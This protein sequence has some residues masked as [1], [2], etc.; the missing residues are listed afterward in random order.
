MILDAVIPQLPMHGEPKLW[1]DLCAAPGGKTGILAR[2]VGKSDVLVAN[3]LN[4]TRLAVL[5]ENLVKGGYLNTF[6]AG[7]S[8][9]A[10]PDEAADVILVDAPCTGEGMM[11]KETEAIEQWS[12]SLVQSCSLL[13]REI[14]REAFRICKP[15]GYILYSTC[16]Y[17]P[18][19][20]IDNVAGFISS[21]PADP[22]E[23]TFPSS[24][25]ISTQEMGLA[26]GYQLFPHLV[27]GEG[28]FISVLRKHEKKS[29][30]GKPARR[31][32][33]PFQSLPA[34]IHP[35][36]GTPEAYV[37]LADRPEL[38]AFT[39]SAA[40]QAETVLSGIP[41][42]EPISSFGEIKG[43]DYV[44]SH[45]LAM[46]GLVS[47]R[48]LPVSLD[49]ERALDYLERKIPDN[50]PESTPGWYPVVYASTMLGWCKRTGQGWKNH[51]PMHWRLRNRR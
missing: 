38:F 31:T 32:R 45:F 50:L 49:Y 42:A 19:E 12:P 22:V 13:Q 16:S 8:A 2:H 4:R 14:V 18:E 28:L 21:F 36:I 44:P 39:E 27:R 33:I 26:T 43:K 23:L 20:N 37:V 51:Y 35:F 41:R 46:A 48:V 5:R 25:H 1:L 34:M 7:E 3:E 40:Q 6:I 9:V 24:W 47:P 11:R 17:S 29:T 10:L 30:T 15:G